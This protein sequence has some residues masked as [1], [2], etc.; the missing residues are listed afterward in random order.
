MTDI[1]ITYETLFDLLR[2]EKNR[3]NI[4]KLDETFFQDVLKYLNEKQEIIKKSNTH[5]ELFNPE[6]TK[7]TQQQFNN[8]KKILKELY[9]RREKKILNL[10][11]LSTR[12]GTNNTQ[13]ACLLQEEKILLKEITEVLNRHK[14]E[15]L[16]NLLQLKSPNLVKQQ[17]TDKPKKEESKEES[18]M[19]TVRFIHPVPKFV[20]RQLEIYG[21]YE[22]EE[23]ANLPK[24]IASVLIKKGRAEAM[25]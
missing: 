13:E 16:H 11:L 7:K 5:S 21:P 22:E 3:E 23:I 2:T 17:K 1:K 14:K 24:E 20:G 18:D 6:E 12:T 10:A 8:V 4:Q 25:E 15:V 19:L 9:E